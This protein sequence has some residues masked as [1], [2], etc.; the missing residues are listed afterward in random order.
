MEGTLNDKSE[1]TKTAAG[2][3]GNG[4]D[5]NDR[6]GCIHRN[7]NLSVASANN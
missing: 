4:D 2:L 7:E 3:Q 6:R 1:E 5:Q